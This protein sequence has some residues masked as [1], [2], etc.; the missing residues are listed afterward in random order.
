[1]HHGTTKV[2]K[3]MHGRILML[4]SILPIY[5]SH[6]SSPYLVSEVFVQKGFLFNSLTLSLALFSKKKE[7]LKFLAFWESKMTGFY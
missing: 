7:N 3:Q 5:D 2:K 1:M 6:L 4:L